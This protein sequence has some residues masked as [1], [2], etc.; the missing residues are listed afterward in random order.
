MVTLLQ[1][2]LTSVSVS[3]AHARGANADE[4][5]PSIYWTGFVLSLLLAVPAFVL[6]SYAEAILLAFHEPALLARTL[7]N[8]ARCCAGARRAA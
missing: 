6:L 2:V 1:G 7:A 3:V 4:C 5:V 8:T